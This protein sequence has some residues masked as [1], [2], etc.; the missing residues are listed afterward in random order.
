MRRFIALLAASLFAAGGAFAADEAVTIK[1]KKPGPGDV[2]KETKTEKAV[3]KV[4]VNVMGTDRVQE[5]TVTSKFAYIDEVVEKP[6]AAKQ[7]TKVKRTYENASVQ[8]GGKDE[9][10]G[11][12][13]KTVVIEKKGD[14]YSFTIDGK[15]VS[16]LA[17]DVLRK[18]FGKDK[19]ITEEDFLPKEPVKVGGTWKLDIA[20]FAKDLS[21]DAQMSADVEKSSGT[22]KLVK[23]YDKDGHKF[24]VLEIK[25]ELVITKGGRPGQEMAMKPGS[26]MKLTV[27]IDACI[28]G[29]SANGTSKVQVK[30]D[31]SGSMNNVTVK[32]DLTAEEEGTTEE[33]KKK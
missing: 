9:D 13:G 20:K 3:N 15:E 7:P 33:V 17:A 6:A 5:E 19:E 27:N 11:L 22:G 18:E 16:R 32:V 28:D 12:A 4:T 31:L 14:S 2:V 26:S 30:G 1:V 24:G 8:K 29:T 23:V 25:M 21:A 10:A